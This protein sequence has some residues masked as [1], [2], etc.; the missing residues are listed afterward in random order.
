MPAD[1]A[2]ADRSVSNG[3]G[4][5]NVATGASVSKLTAAFAPATGSDADS[6]VLPASSV[7][8]CRD[9]APSA[10]LAPGDD[11]GPAGAAWRA[12]LAGVTAGTEPG[13]RSTH[14]GSGGS[15]ST[16]PSP[17]ASPSAPP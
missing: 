16:R 7:A 5:P 2:P 15:T 17:R 12:P 11:D 14:L 10:G 13:S 6:V 4:R 8:V 3:S 9:I 1:S